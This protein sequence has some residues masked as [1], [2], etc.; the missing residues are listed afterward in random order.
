[1]TDN[2]MKNRFIGGQ[3]Q[4]QRSNRHNPAMRNAFSR[5]DS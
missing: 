1:M 3:L 2:T 4:T 5:V